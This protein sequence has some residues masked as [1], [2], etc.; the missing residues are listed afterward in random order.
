MK[1]LRDVFSYG[2]IHTLHIQIS[3]HCFFC[4]RKQKSGWPEWLWNTEILRSGLPV[5][6]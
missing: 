1:G 5:W 2:K 3:P 6:N 4:I